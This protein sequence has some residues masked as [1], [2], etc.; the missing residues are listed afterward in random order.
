MPRRTKTSIWL[1]ER[2]AYSNQKAKAKRRGIPFNFEFK[3]WI[4]WWGLDYGKRGTSTG[5]GLVMARYNDTGPYELGNVFKCT[6]AQN[7]HD[8]RLR[9][10]S[11][12]SSQD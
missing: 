9:E 7:V 5:H 1:D 6:N 2:V 4:L 12:G 3:E 11:D 8:A 10:E